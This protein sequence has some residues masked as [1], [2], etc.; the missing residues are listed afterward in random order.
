MCIMFQMYRHISNISGTF[1]GNKSVGHPDVVGASPVDAAPIASSFSSKH[2]APMEW[3]ETTA[4]RDDSYFKFVR[5]GA[6]Y[7]RVLMLLYYRNCNLGMADFCI[8]VTCRRKMFF[9]HLE[10]Y[11]FLIIYRLVGGLH[12]CNLHQTG[13]QLHGGIFCIIN[14][15]S[16]TRGGGGGRGRG[17][18]RG[19]QVSTC[20]YLIL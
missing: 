19:Y 16:Y 2:V 12:Q 5:F 20:V 13:R 6:L 18:Q 3:A 15:M 11:G 14:L 10:S 7:I 8:S 4:R 1:V 17:H 9:L